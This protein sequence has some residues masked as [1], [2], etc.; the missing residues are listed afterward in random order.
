MDILTL[1]PLEKLAL[2]IPG[3]HP[4]LSYPILSPASHSRQSKTLFFSYLF[5]FHYESIGTLLSRA[6]YTTSGLPFIA[7]SYSVILEYRFIASFYSIIL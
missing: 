3:L 5:I 1:R 6:L 7:S 4:I 2:C